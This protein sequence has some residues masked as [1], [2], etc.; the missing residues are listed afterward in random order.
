MS[1]EL[2]YY[3][4]KFLDC[5]IDYN[6]EWRT[7]RIRCTVC[8]HT[9]F[10]KDIKKIIG[11]KCSHDCHKLIFDNKQKSDKI[12][13]Y[14]SKTNFELISYAENIANL[15]CS[16][17][18]WEFCSSYANVM[19]DKARCLCNPQFANLRKMVRELNGQNKYLR[20]GYYN[21]QSGV[22]SLYCTKYDYTTKIT[23]N[24]ATTWYK[25]NYRNKYADTHL[26]L[27]YP[28]HHN[29]HN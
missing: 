26:N 24:E 29:I 28:W 22:Y 14:L 25:R 6:L 21:H 4:S 17:C 5:D 2:Y 13:E 8:D 11:C 1:D 23:E 20:I 12:S 3:K 27:A 9:Y 16:K 19:S 15:Y 10:R 7:Y 18:D